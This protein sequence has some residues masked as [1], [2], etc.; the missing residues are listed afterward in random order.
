MY[1]LTTLDAAEEVDLY[2]LCPYIILVCRFMKQWATVQGRFLQK[3][4]LPSLLSDPL[5]TWHKT[6]GLP[7][8][9]TNSANSQNTE[10][11]A[12]KDLGSFLSLGWVSEAHAWAGMLLAGVRSQWSGYH[13]AAHTPAP[14]SW[15]RS[16][17]M[18]LLQVPKIKASTM[19]TTT[20]AK[21]PLHDL[22]IRS[23]CEFGSCRSH[24]CSFYTSANTQNHL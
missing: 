10:D 15:Q 6:L 14:A 18:K 23:S 8:L 13:Q 5:L 21:L 11:L 2:S 24:P 16:L 20:A 17:S 4:L 7:D 22:R 1:L 9:F 19:S 3:L 12:R